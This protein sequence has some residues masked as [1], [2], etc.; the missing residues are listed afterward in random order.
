MAKLKTIFLADLTHT[1]SGIQALTFP[2]GT[3][4]VAAYAQ[5]ILGESFEFK[6]FKFP[7]KL[8]QAIDAG[9]PLV[10][11]LSN[12]FWNLELSCKLAAWARRRHPGLVVVMGGPNFSIWKMKK[13]NFFKLGLPLISTSNLKVNWVFQSC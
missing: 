7:E 8:S 9:H 1:H 6:L 4:Y 12:Y 3:A 2:L 13:L 5:K 11:A 10:L